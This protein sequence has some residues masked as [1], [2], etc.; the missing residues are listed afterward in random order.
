MNIFFLS[1]SK[2]DA[3]KRLQ[4]VL[5]YM[6]PKK[7]IKYIRSIPELEKNLRKTTGKLSLALILHVGREQLAG[8]LS[9]K[10]LFEDTSL[11][12]ILKDK[13]AEIISMG[14]HLRPR[15]ITYADSD[16]LDVASVLMKMKEKMSLDEA[17]RN[18]DIQPSGAKYHG[19]SE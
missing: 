3:R 9:I 13:D 7:N 10:E 4:R 16:F 17:L 11:I 5:E 15:F 6:L 14:H 12:L 2:N 18:P 1:G 8:L 19:H